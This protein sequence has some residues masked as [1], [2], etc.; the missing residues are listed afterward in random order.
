MEWIAQ[1]EECCQVG[2]DDYRMVK[3]TLKLEPTT[4]LFQ[5]VEWAKAG[6]GTHIELFQL[7]SIEPPKPSH[8]G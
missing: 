2:P 3:R 7:E 5:I 1:I 6:K 8:N 4:R